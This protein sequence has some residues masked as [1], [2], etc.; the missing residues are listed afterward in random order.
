MSLPVWSHVPS[1]RVRSQEGIVLGGNGSRRA[2]GIPYPLVLTFSVD[3]QS[4]RYTSYWNAF[5]LWLIQI[6]RSR[7]GLGLGFG[8]QTLWLHSIIQNFSHWFRSGSG[9][10]L[11]WFPK[12]LLYQF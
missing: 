12:W 2:Y 4:G 10:L 5:L 6:A 9:S 11:R 8:L 3:H 7:L 1:S